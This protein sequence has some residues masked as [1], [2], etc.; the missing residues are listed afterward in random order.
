MN[1]V[2]VAVSVAVAGTFVVVGYAGFSGATIYAGPA[3]WQAVMIIA[4]TAAL[5]RHS[6]QLVLCENNLL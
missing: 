3:G 4:S 1:A 5:D 6:N 2:A